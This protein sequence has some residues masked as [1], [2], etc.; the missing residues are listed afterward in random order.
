[1]TSNLTDKLKEW[2]KRAREIKKRLETSY[3]ID[4]RK[5]LH[6]TDKKTPQER[7]IPIDDLRAVCIYFLNFDSNA[8][9]CNNLNNDCR[10]VRVIAQHQLENFGG[11]K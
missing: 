6:D 10:F 3:V 5:L 11:G 4:M 8:D 1:M 7:A 9:G 2:K